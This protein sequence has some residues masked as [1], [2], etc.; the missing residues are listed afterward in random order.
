M[1]DIADDLGARN[2]ARRNKGRGITMLAVVALADF[3]LFGQEPGINLFAFA[4]AVTIGIL[5]PAIGSLGS[6]MACLLLGFSILV[7]APL[8]EAPSLLGALLSVCAAIFVALACSR[9]VPE[10]MT[11]LPLIFFRFA[12]VAPLRLMEDCLKRL[13]LAAVQPVSGRLSRSLVVWTVPVTL[14]SIFLVLFAM[15]NPLIEEGLRSIDLSMLLSLLDFWRITFWLIIAMSIWPLLRPRLK[16]RHNRPTVTA[17]VEMKENPLFGHASLLRSLL[18]FNALFA[19]QSLLDL[20]YLWGGA[21]LPDGMSHAE[22]AHR[23]AYP[24]VA[25]ALLAAAFVLAAMRRNDPGDGSPLIRSLVYVWIGQNILLC[26]ASILRLDLYVEVYS[27]T[28]L[29]VAAGIWMGLV[30]TGL[31]LIL[32]RILL[33]RSSEWLIATNLAALVAVLYVCAFID[34]PAFISRFNVEHSRELGGQGLALDICY[35]RS[36]GPS[37]IPALDRYITALAPLAPEEMKTAAITREGLAYQFAQRSRDW[38]SWNL[39]A[40]RLESTLAQHVAIAR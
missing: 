26:I 36:L 39:R 30:A 20:V 24:L 7:S 25:T 11:G 9:L 18:I 27:L 15:A 40:W 31:A 34:F 17:L 29:R 33:R 28:E 21:D 22:Y 19:V 37:A 35:L 6:R 16:R 13:L 10:S 14:A 8:L 5:L 1:T 3:L 4:V 23:G 2:P 12:L 38:R 32:L